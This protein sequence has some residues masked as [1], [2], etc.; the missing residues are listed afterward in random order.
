[1]AFMRLVGAIRKCGHRSSTEKW[2]YKLR[3][4]ENDTFSGRIF[5][6][7]IANFTAN[8][9]AKRCDYDDNRTSTELIATFPQDIRKFAGQAHFPSR[10]RYVNAHVHHKQLFN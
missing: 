2:E 5:M 9:V 1:M 3:H 8:G 4:R 7:T 10:T 6:Q